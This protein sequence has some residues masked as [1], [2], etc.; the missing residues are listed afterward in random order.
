VREGSTFDELT[1]R[2]DRE[3]SLGLM[4]S[5]SIIAYNPLW[6]GEVW[7]RKPVFPTR[8]AAPPITALGNLA[9]G[10]TNAGRWHRV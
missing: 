9:L 5:N 7:R 3:A 8:L 4:W 6:R 2:C 1:N 10:G